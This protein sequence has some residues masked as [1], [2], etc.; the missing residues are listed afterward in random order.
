VLNTGTGGIGIR[1][2]TATAAYEIGIITV[3]SN[4]IDGAYTCIK[5]NSGGGA[6]VSITNN[7]T[8]NCTAGEQ[9]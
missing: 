8:T 5:N 6:T 1:V 7:T 2:G 9:P 3:D 4:E